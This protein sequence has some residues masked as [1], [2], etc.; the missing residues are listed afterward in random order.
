MKPMLKFFIVVVYF[1]FFWG[2]P[3]AYGGFQARGLIGATAAS[4]RHSHSNARSKPCLWPTHH[5]SQQHWILNP[6]SEARDW[7]CNRM[8]PSLIQFCCATTELP[9]AKKLLRCFTLLFF[10]VRFQSPV[11]TYGTSQFKGVQLEFLSWGS[12]NESD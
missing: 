1:C 12:G 8:V 3:T 2:K 5:S 7:T 9:N 4:L 10:I 11:Y 6:L